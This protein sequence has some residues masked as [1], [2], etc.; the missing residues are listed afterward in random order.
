LPEFAKRNSYWL[1]L[2][3]QSASVIVILY[4]GVPLYQQLTVEIS[5]PPDRTSLLWGLA[6][7]LAIQIAHW[8]G[9]DDFPQHIPFANLLLGTVVQFLARLS[10]IYASAMF[11]IVIFVRSNKMDLV[12]WHIVLLFIVMFSM[13]CYSNELERLGRAIAAAP[14]DRRDLRP[15]NS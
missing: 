1:R 8:A 6:A 3:A 14:T 5:A 2:A 11:S 7:A 12:F 15:N 4:Q 13:F 10:F 9:K